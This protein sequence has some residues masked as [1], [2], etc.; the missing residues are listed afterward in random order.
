MKRKHTEKSAYVSSSSTTSALLTTTTTTATAAA[1]V[2]GNLSDVS[3]DYED[4]YNTEVANIQAQLDQLDKKIHP[5]FVKIR[6]EVEHW[7]S[8]QKQRI[9]IL[10]EHKGNDRYH[11][12]TYWKDSSSPIL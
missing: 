2:Q 5:E 9:H 1:I 12:K 4:T 7:Y 11:I 3:D 10:H 8:E 6:E